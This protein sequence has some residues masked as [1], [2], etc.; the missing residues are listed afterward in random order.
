MNCLKSLK[1]TQN[2][3]Q[4][5]LSGAFLEVVNNFVSIFLKF[6]FAIYKYETVDGRIGLSFREI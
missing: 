1:T 6:F 4:D 3:R 2:Y 5:I